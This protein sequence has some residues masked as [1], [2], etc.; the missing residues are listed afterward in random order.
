[1]SPIR[2]RIKAYARGYRRERDWPALIPCQAPADPAAR[3]TIARRAMRGERSRGLAGHWSF[4]AVRL[5]GLRA[6]YLA[7][8]LDALRARRGGVA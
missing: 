7:E 1:M 5:V 4:S 8:R 6:L 2:E 3:V